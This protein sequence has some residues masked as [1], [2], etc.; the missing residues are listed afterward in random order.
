MCAESGS[1]HEAIRI[2]LDLDGLLSETTTL[3]GAMC[4]IG[5][6]RRAEAEPG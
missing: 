3:R 5:R 4:L 1:E 6:M 2:A